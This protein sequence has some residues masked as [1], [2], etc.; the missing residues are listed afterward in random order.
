MVGH[1]AAVEPERPGDVWR[2]RIGLTRPRW[3]TAGAALLFLVISGY[4]TGLA[5]L[6][7]Q[8]GVPLP[9]PLARIDV[10][11]VASGIGAL[12]F[13]TCLVLRV[14][15]RHSGW[16]VWMVGLL[17]ACLVLYAGVLVTGLIILLPLPTDL[18]DELTHGHLIAAVWAA[19]PSL[20]L[21]Y[22]LVRRDRIS[23]AGEL[24]DDSPG[25]RGPPGRWP[26]S[27]PRP[28]RTG[29]ALAALLVALLVVTPAIVLAALAPR[30]L[31]PS[32]VRGGDQS[33]QAIGPR[34]FID[35][36]IPA[37]RG[38]EVIAGGLGLYAV[39]LDG[40]WREIADFAGTDVLSLVEQPDGSIYVGTTLGLYRAMSVNG[41]FVQLPLPGTIVH[42]IAVGEQG[43]LLWASSAQGFWRS[44]DGGAHWQAESTGIARPDTAWALL[45]DRGT[46]YGSDLYGVYR[47]SGAQ[48][49]RESDQGDV[50]SFTR[51]PDGRILASA[52]GGGIWARQDGR[53]LESDAG[54]LSHNQGALRGIHEI[55]VTFDGPTVAYGGSMLDG[56]N[57]S[58]DGGA[59]W[60]QQWPGLS[61]DGDVWRV[62]PI[63]GDLVAATDQGLFRYALPAT[64]PAGPGWW[65]V[66]TGATLVAAVLAA[67][68]LRG[69]YQRIR[70]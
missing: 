38:G 30:A 51:A 44:T 67:A 49:V 12:S 65:L 37:L 8:A 10:V 43:S 47:F 22:E 14:R 50:V 18:A 25:R 32:A 11:H 59:T 41:P 53:W 19:E 62:L 27:T 31:S 70:R 40:G 68:L 64:A 66:A 17:I 21:L 45:D 39:S 13:G 3:G 33:W 42:G 52:M 7:L 2:G 4:L 29:V 16:S 15:S 60:S 54:L 6:S 23:G 28:S 20:L 57:V 48:W 58:R 26:L 34:T 61:R 5:Y 69:R 56:A 63:G 9:L 24:G 1:R 55:S 36:A 46:V 35:Q